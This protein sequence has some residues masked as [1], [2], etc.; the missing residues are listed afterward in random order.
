MDTPADGHSPTMQM[1]LFPANSLG[2]HPTNPDSNGGD[3]ASIVYHEY[4]HGLSHR[5]VTTPNGAPALNTFQ[6]D[7]MGEAWSDWYAMDYLVGRHF[8]Q[9]TATPGDVQLGYYSGGGHTQPIRT[10]GLDCPPSQSKPLCPGAGRAGPGGYTFGDMGKI[11]RGP[12]GVFPEVH[13]DGEIW[14]QTLWQVRQRLIATL[15]PVTGMKRAEDIVTRGMELSPPNPSFLDMRNAILQ[16]DQVVAGGHDHDLLWSVFAARGM[17]FYA[18]TDGPNDTRPVQ[19]FAAPP[20]CANPAHCGTI[21]GTI[22]DADTHDPLH[23]VVVSVVDHMTPGSGQSPDNLVDVTA[24]DGSYSIPDVPRHS[25]YRLTTM[26]DG[27]ERSLA[28][29]NVQSASVTVNRAI[30]RDWAASSGGA[31]IISFTR[32]NYTQF[33]CGP[34]GAIDTSQ[35]VGWGSDAPGNPNSGVRGPRQ[36]TI[37]LPHAVDIDNFAVDPSETCGDF[38]DAAVKSFKIETK[39]ASGPFVV[40]INR[41][42][43]LL[44]HRFTTLTPSQGKSRVLFVRFTMRSNRGD[45][46]FMDMT[47]LLVHGTQSP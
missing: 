10:E 27:Y 13:A 22:T 38:S 5:L 43:P 36:I 29:V 1:Y 35:A 15:G 45:R 18:H 40:A 32:P 17:G 20:S 31:R 30:R 24:A 42:Q 23:G 26:F 44:L 9:D 28:T 12:F 3:E 33:G 6:S 7:S 46:A 16:A 19:N 25:G 47:E 14:G 39:K 34:G 21:E 37:R 41:T 8:E 2:F 4:T 11:A